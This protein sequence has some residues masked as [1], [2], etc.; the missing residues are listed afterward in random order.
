MSSVGGPSS[1][2]SSSANS[3]RYR[4]KLQPQPPEFPFIGKPFTIQVFLVDSKDTIK[5][6]ITVPLDLELFYNTAST[7]SNDPT[8]PMSS[9][10]SSNVGL[11]MAMALNRQHP[12]VLSIEP[13]Q[14][15]IEPKT[16]SAKISVAIHQLSMHHENK[17][18]MLKIKALGSEIV[19]LG[20]PV[21]PATSTPM[22]VVKHRII[23]TQQPPDIW[24]KDEGGRENSMEVLAKLVDENGKQVQGRI[25]PLQVHLL[26]HGS[27]SMP[28][29][30]ILTVNNVW[31]NICCLTN[32]Q[33]REIKLRLTKQA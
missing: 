19:E 28:N 29:Q 9:S 1:M 16:G 18:F 21:D 22:L 17:K 12:G 4:L 8:N 32:F 11:M 5:T 3:R 24:Y 31:P 10:S 25:I 15:Y 27:D 13:Q 6:G 14:P 7:S 33:L 30:N 23:I 2:S 26:Y 20:G